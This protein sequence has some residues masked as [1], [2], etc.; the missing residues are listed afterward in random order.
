METTTQYL[1]DFH[2]PA[3]A[4]DRSY[5]PDLRSLFTNAEKYRQVHGITPA[6]NDRFKISL[7]LIDLQ[8]DFCFPDGAL[9]VAGRSGTGAID[10]NRRLT[11]FIYRNL[12]VISEVTP[13]LDTHFPYQIFFPSFWLDEDDQPLQP[14]DQL[15]GEQR[16]LRQGR[17]MGRAYVNPAVAPSVAGGNYGWLKDYAAHYCRTLEQEGKYLLYIW[18]EHCLLGSDGHALAGVVQEARMFHAFVRQ[19]QSKAE[20]KGGN[21]LTENYSVFSPEV[22]TAHDG[23]AIG[24]KSGRFISRLLASDAVVIAGQAA[25]HCVKSSIDHLLD[26]IQA[27]DPELAKKVYILSDCTSSVTVPDGQGGLAVDFTDQTEQALERYESGGMNLVSSTVAIEEWPG[28]LL[29]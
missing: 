24:Q 26:E 23:R 20:V 16:I 7:L 18:P 10:D 17:E 28:I 2:D 1:P 13:T 3:N 6:A 27:K 21:P 22:L 25:S 9:W 29:G 14:H 15:T 19:T 5:D 11:D 4:A 8:R 12:E